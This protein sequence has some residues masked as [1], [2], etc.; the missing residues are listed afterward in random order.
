[1][2]Q[3][4]KFAPISD[5][6]TTSKSSLT[7]SYESPT[8]ST[9]SKDKL[10]VSWHNLSY[11]VDNCANSPSLVQR[12]CHPR[13]KTRTDKLHVILNSLSGHF[14]SGEL[15]AVMGPSGS[16]KTTLLE[17][18]AGK[19]Q[20]GVTG[21]VT[22]NGC[23]KAKL[24]FIGQNDQLLC[25]M[26]VRETI[27]YASK[28]KNSK[29]NEAVVGCDVNSN[30]LVS[31]DVIP[32]EK[33]GTYSNVQNDM[34]E[35]RHHHVGCDHID[36]IAITEK[37]LDQFGLQ[38]CADVRVSHISGGQLKRLSIAQELV[39]KPNLLIL[40]EPTSGL[41]S[42]SCFQCVELLLKLAQQRDYEH[43]LAIV[44]TIH[45]PSARVFMM[46]QR[47]YFLST[48]GQCIYD[49]APSNLVEYLSGVGLNCP[50]FNNPADY[51]TEI[52]S[53]DYGVECVAR[54]SSLAAKRHEPFFLPV[55]GKPTDVGSVEKK[56]RPQQKYP[57]FEHISLLFQRTFLSI[58]RDPMLSTLRFVS[59][60]LVAVFIGLLYGNKIG[61][62][63]GCP[64]IYT[65]E[66]VGST[67]K[68]LY[69]D[70]IATSENVANLFFCAMFVMYGALMPTVLT[71]PMELH[72]FLKER[73]NGWYSVKTYYLAKTL[74]DIPLQI[75]FPVFYAIIVYL[76]NGQIWSPWRFGMFVFI[77]VLVGLVAQSQGLLVSALF[78]D[79]PSSAV[80]VAPM[81]SVPFLLFAGFFVRIKTMPQYLVVVSYLSYVRYAFEAL[82]SVMYGFDRCVTHPLE[83]KSDGTQSA[84]LNFLQLFFSSDYDYDDGVTNATNVEPPASKKLIES[85]VK[86]LQE[87]N[88]FIS[89]VFA[90]KN[91]TESY[92]LSQFDL[93]D[94][95]LYVNI[96]RLVICFFVLRIACYLILLYK[97]SKKR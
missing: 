35:K 52:A 20:V 34:I 88:P 60:L 41:D 63:S 94:Y 46:F 82:I 89:D 2:P 5:G 16:G 62:A 69:D 64:P 71:F 65:L 79:D 24:S 85:I 30:H 68:H 57:F 93:T 61:Q 96:M 97:T 11:V 90:S 80:F 14:K 51:M 53:E 23:D 54:L 77:F 22:L 13:S 76:M 45:Q 17:C 48:K 29:K 32:N 67:Q 18:L 83:I 58:V 37:L 84:L 21:D 4:T 9:A 56:L 36:H 70:I 86:D 87:N 19:R 8:L 55:D 39:S 72:V 1:M 15:T 74:A 28:L 78:L 43:P 27:L 81:T 59:H 73:N 3:L 91:T 31:V 92:V 49:G 50:P 33:I 7:E 25:H 42:A 95:S 75:V 66:T 40:D 38:K 47:V 26:T 6:R 44:A 10:E 12:L